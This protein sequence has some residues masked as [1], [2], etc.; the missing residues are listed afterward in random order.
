MNSES[1]LHVGALSIDLHIQSSNSLK[2]KRMVLRSI[3]D[4]IR[5]KFNVSVAEVGGQDK[6]QACT[7]GICMVGNDKKLIDAS[8]Q[9][10][11]TVI[12][13]ARDVTVTDH[14]LQFL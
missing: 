3:K 5:D 10:I 2:S 7:L 6:W 12:S 1:M 14:E 11:L 8:L 13:Q 9:T 4:R